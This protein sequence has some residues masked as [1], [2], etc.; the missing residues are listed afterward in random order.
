MELHPLANPIQPS[1]LTALLGFQLVRG[2]PE[3]G[4]DCVPG[5]AP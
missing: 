1:I 3:V 2:R 4:D 5:H